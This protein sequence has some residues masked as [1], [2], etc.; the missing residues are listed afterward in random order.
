MV[1]D[2]HTPIRTVRI[3]DALW[4]A[5]HEKSQADGTTVSEVIRECLTRYVNKG[6]T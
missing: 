2:S 3:D 6:R 4:A 5:V 1:R